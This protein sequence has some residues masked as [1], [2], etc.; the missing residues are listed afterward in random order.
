M[1]DAGFVPAQFSMVNRAP[2]D[3]AAAMEFDCVF[4]RTSKTRTE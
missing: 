2:G 4:R 1:A 3:A